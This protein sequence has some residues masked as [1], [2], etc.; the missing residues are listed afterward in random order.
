MRLMPSNSACAKFLPATPWMS[1]DIQG[2]H[3]LVIHLALGQRA[4]PGDDVRHADAAFAEHAFLA[5]PRIIPRAVPA[6]PVAG[7]VFHVKL[8]GRAVITDE[9]DQCVVGQAVLIEALTNASDAIIHCR[10]HRQCDPTT[11]GHLPGE[12]AEIFVRRVQRHVR[13]EVC[14]VQKERFILAT[15]DKR[16]GCIGLDVEAIARSGLSEPARRR[17]PSD[18]T[19]PGSG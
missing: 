8:N 15:I 5:D 6:G 3:R 17:C 4:G 12:S 1:P 14:Q 2:N 13:R 18:R 9:E 7:L 10:E 11:P 16:Q 19:W